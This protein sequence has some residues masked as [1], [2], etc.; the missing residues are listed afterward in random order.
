MSE[1]DKLA[2]YYLILIVAIYLPYIGNAQELFCND[3]RIPVGKACKVPN[4]QVVS[5]S[6]INECVVDTS[7]HGALIGDKCGCAN[8]YRWTYYYNA[9]LAEPGTSCSGDVSNCLDREPLTSKCYSSTCQC[10]T[11]YA[12]NGVKCGYQNNGRS[13]SSGHQCMENGSRGGCLGNVCTCLPGY[14]WSAEH[15]ICRHINNDTF[16][17]TSIMDCYINDARGLC[18][19]K[20]KCSPGYSYSSSLENCIGANDNAHICTAVG[21]CID[22]E[23]FAA[24]TNSLCTCIPGTE[25]VVSEKKCKPYNDN[26]KA[27][28]KL[29]ECFYTNA[30]SADCALGKCACQSWSQWDGIQKICLLPNNG[31]SKCSQL[32]QCIDSTNRAVCSREC[33]CHADCRDD[34]ITKKCR[35]PN[36]NIFTCTTV[37]DCYDTGIGADCISGKCTCK[38]GYGWIAAEEKCKPYNT[39]SITGSC[40]GSVSVCFDTSSTLAFCSSSSCSCVQYS[41]WDANCRVCTAPNNKKYECCGI[42]A[43]QDTGI[44][45]ICNGKCLCKDGY[46]WDYYNHKC[47]DTPVCKADLYDEWTRIEVSCIQPLNARYIY[48]N[49]V[50]ST[51][52][53]FFATETLLLFGEAYSCYH[54]E[55]KI[56]VR[57]GTNAYFKPD[58]VLVPR[59]DRF[60]LDDTSAFVTKSIPISTTQAAPLTLVATKTPANRPVNLCE[61]LVFTL[62]QFT[63]MG[64]RPKFAY[65]AYEMNECRS[66]DKDN[67][68]YLVFNENCRRLNSFVG[69]WR[70]KN[71]SLSA[72]LLLENAIYYLKVTYTT[73]LGRVEYYIKI[74]TSVAQPFTVFLPNKEGHTYFVHEWEEIIISP[75]ITWMD[76]SLIEKDRYYFNWTQKYEPM[77]NTLNET[78]FNSLYSRENGYIYIPPYTLVPDNSH[79][80]T[81]NVTHRDYPKFHSNLTVYIK[82]YPS[83]LTAQIDQGDQKIFFNESLFL[84]ASIIEDSIF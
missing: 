2:I 80:F 34:P 26:G 4:D 36:T 60:I 48:S 68:R 69:S 49:N 82:V 75:Q 63:G 72:G 9:C 84:S 12:F 7:R 41:S 56:T 6:N 44:G 20:C 24:C 35:A 33:K 45:A 71:E 57:L 66:D 65:L 52:E 10:M 37:S 14:K 47:V 46:E 54:N 74:E 59:K 78:Y 83:R 1:H 3:H 50:A 13:C 30:V 8:G 15:L 70:T 19:N 38:T 11:D 27:C 28:S 21:D 64:N 22:A 76:C 5:V 16:S 81:L 23:S 32:S 67:P 18:D 42:S 25:W 62:S 29:S 77:L 58:S 53:A 51:C 79:Y 55:N 61:T 39:N 43:C 17:C 31:T 73:Y 40:T